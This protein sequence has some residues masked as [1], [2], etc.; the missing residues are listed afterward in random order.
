MIKT[1]LLECD[2]KFI[3]L[4]KVHHCQ[5][6]DTAFFMHNRESIQFKVNSCVTI[7]AVFFQQINSN[8]AKPSIDKQATQKLNNDAFDIWR[9]SLIIITQQSN[10]VKSNEIESIKL[11]ENELLVCSSTVLKFS[12]GDKMWCEYSINHWDIL[13]YNL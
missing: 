11:D 12:F 5:F 8:Y 3:S 13:A 4:M 7:N 6:Q 1:H 10:K 2:Q 9:F